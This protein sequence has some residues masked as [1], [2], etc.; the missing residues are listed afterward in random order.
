MG[1]LKILYFQG[2]IMSFFGQTTHNQSNQLDIIDIVDNLD[3]SVK[4]GDNFRANCPICGSS[5]SRPFVLFGNGGYFCHSCNEKGGF[6]KLITDIFKLDFS[7]FKDVAKK[8]NPF[9]KKSKNVR[10]VS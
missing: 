3:N 5:S 9:S 1:L 4:S 6:F 7:S 10:H 2:A 8:F